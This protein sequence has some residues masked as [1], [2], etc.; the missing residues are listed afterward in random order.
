[1]SGSFWPR[2]TFWPAPS[3]VSVT[4]G[5]KTRKPKHRSW[6][7]SRA[8]RREGCIAGLGADQNRSA[9]II[10]TKKKGAT[11]S[12]PFQDLVT[13]HCRRDDATAVR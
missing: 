3:D 9:P 8:G 4:C 13:R 5:F 2:G 7:G 1:M 6:D 10:V 12:R 11:P